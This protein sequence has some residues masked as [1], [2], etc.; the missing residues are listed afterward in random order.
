MLL[1]AVAREPESDWRVVLRLEPQARVELREEKP[2]D[3][4]KLR[5]EEKPRL[6]K[7]RPPPKPP[8]RAKASSA[9]SSRHRVAAMTS[10]MRRRTRNARGGFPRPAPRTGVRARAAAFTVPLP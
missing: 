6:L 3:E 10:R 1:R 4:E 7:E 9:T 2:R 5:D 8:R